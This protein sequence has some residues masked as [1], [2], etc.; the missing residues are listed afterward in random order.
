M[1]QKPKPFMCN[2]I[3]NK[4]S[5]TSSPPLTP[6]KIYVYMVKCKNNTSFNLYHL[7]Q[8]LYLHIDHYSVP[9]NNWNYIIIQLLGHK[10]N[11]LIHH[12]SF[13]Y[14][15]HELYRRVG[16]RQ[17]LNYHTRRRTLYVA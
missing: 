6:T 10:Q 15:L 14:R 5:P 3:I 8:L 12:P 16:D 9:S 4:D 7:K 1:S 17:R 11:P 2:G 13:S